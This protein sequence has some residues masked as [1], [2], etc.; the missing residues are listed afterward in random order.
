[1]WRSGCRL[2]RLGRQVEPSRAHFDN[3]LKNFWNKRG[4]DS[5]RQ[6]CFEEKKISFPPHFDVSHETIGARC[7]FRHTK[8]E[9]RVFTLSRT[10]PVYPA[11]VITH[12][13][14]RKK[15][16]VQTTM[17]A[18][19]GSWIAR[20]IITMPIII[21]SRNVGKANNTMR[22]R[23]SRSSLGL[24]ILFFPFFVD[25]LTLNSISRGL[26]KVAVVVCLTFFWEK[27]LLLFLTCFDLQYYKHIK[28]THI[29]ILD[30]TRYQQQ[31]ERR[32][33]KFFFF[34]FSRLKG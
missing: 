5:D 25:D 16:G 27:S 31:I 4:L 2:L 30:R 23:D 6:R 15:K 20:L 13:G 7:T 8:K 18:N 32:E 1:M 26:W 19:R 29:S 14:R 34:F 11:A 28:V 21:Q 17:G 24:T 12:R 22:R 33:E 10:A 9:E 3:M